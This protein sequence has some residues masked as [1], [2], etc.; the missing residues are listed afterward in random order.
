MIRGKTVVIEGNDGTGKSTQVELLA[1]WLKQEKNIDSYV[2][3]EPAGTP[4]ADAIREI[5]KN[6]S[7]DRSPKTNLLLFTAARHEIHLREQRE[8]AKGNWV[9]KA[10]DWSSTVAYQGSGEGLSPQFIEDITRI[11][12]DDSYMN[13]DYKIILTL[14]NITRQERISGRGELE[15]LDTFESKD[16]NF[17][18]RVN[19]AYLNIATAKGYP[20][21][22][23]GQSIEAVQAEIRQII[24]EL[25]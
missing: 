5:I 18:Q 3:H 16:V 14:D 17:Q 24:A 10:R 6:G 13:P 15:N 21:I 20:T 25:G 11:F 22:D 23:A 19:E 1:E 4:T 2:A 9:L 8:L 7:L 12:T